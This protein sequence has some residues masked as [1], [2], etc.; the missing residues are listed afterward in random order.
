MSAPAAQVPVPSPVS[1]L[2][3]AYDGDQI[4]LVSEQQVTMII[5]LSHP[6]G[7]LETSASFSV[8]LKDQRG[9][10]VYGRVFPSPFGFDR[11]IFDKD[12]K[13]SIRREVNPHPKG[14][15]VV[16]VPAVA[17]ARRIEFFGHPLKPKAHLESPRRLASFSLKPLPSR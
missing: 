14:T 3:F 4:H 10:A 12:P 2:T 7:D 17:N 5:P 13:R 8:I 9:E 6:L 1:R 15:F 11:E 16:L